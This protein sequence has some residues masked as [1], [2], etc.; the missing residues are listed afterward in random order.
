MPSWQRRAAA[1]LFRRTLHCRAVGPVVWRNNCSR[2]L[3]CRAITRDHDTMKRLMAVSWLVPGRGPCRLYHAYLSSLC[4]FPDHSPFC[5]S[6]S[7]QTERGSKTGW[8]RV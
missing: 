4:V 8:D 6:R 7:M 3:V 5:A 1:T 2:D